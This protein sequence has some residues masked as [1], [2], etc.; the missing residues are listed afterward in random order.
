M[1]PA[2]ILTSSRPLISFRMVQYAFEKCTET[3]FRSA[4]DCCNNIQDLKKD[5]LYNLLV[6]IG[7]CYN[8]D[9]DFVEPKQAN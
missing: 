5:I 6:E 3:P 7:Q 4:T 9:V 2:A 1:G 8:K